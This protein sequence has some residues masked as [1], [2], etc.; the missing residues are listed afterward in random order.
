MCEVNPLAAEYSKAILM[1][2]VRM[3]ESTDVEIV[4]QQYIDSYQTIIKEYY[5]FCEFSET[6]V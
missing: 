1:R 2:Y 3:L 6:G 4:R 5:E